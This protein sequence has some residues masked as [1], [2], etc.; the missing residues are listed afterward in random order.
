[1]RSSSMR[2][3]FACSPA[4]SVVVSFA[5]LGARRREP[6][7]ARMLDKMRCGHREPR[8]VEQQRL[9]EHGVAFRERQLAALA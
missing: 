6:L 9:G 3:T 7:G 1:M 5:W 8:R 4:S 2:C